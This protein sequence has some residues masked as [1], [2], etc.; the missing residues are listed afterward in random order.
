MRPQYVWFLILLDYQ[1]THYSL[2]YRWSYGANRVQVDA[3]IKVLS[4]F[5]EYLQSDSVRGLP[6]ISSLSPNRVSS[7]GGTE[8]FWQMSNQL[9]YNLL[10]SD[11]AVRMRGLNLPLRLLTENEIFRLSVWNNPTNE[12]SKGADLVGNTERTLFEARISIISSLDSLLTIPTDVMVRHRSNTLAYKPSYFN[13]PHWTLQNPNDS[14]GGWE[15]GPLKHHWRSWYS[16]G[17]VFP[18]WW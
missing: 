18:S 3:D 13:L 8:N 1:A 14:T 10:P 11:H 7:T 2:S 17:T 12:T 9:P 5:L 4:E 15:V 16:W 6:S